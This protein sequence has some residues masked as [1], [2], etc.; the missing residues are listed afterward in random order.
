MTCA[1]L[2]ACSPT[3]SPKESAQAL[4]SAQAP[5]LWEHPPTGLFV[6]AESPSWVMTQPKLPAGVFGV[7]LD[8]GEGCLGVVRVQRAPKAGDEARAA[9]LERR[10]R[11]R[12]KEAGVSALE[13][14]DQ[15]EVPLGSYRALMMRVKGERGGQ[16]WFA[17]VLA[18]FLT[19][20]GVRYYAEVRATS[21][22]SGIVARRECYDRLVRSVT[23]PKELR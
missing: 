11:R 18:T 19:R 8:A 12:L 5:E 21:D 13:V 10:I 3:P 20:Q 4:E 23:I 6:E 17:R 9:E 16:P 15:G 22:A 7:D 14:R 2:L 1:L